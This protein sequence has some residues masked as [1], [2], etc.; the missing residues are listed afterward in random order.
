MNHRMLAHHT[1][2]ATYTVYTCT[3]ILIY[4]YIYTKREGGLERERRSQ[5]YLK[6]QRQ[7]RGRAIRLNEQQ[8]FN[9]HVRV[10]GYT[11]VCECNPHVHVY[12]SVC[13]CVAC[14]FASAYCLLKKTYVCSCLN[15][16]YSRLLQIY[17]EALLRQDMTGR[18][19]PIHQRAGAPYCHDQVG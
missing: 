1:Y 11:Y 5:T 6:T 17:P 4:K 10:Y 18:R 3:N 16:F 13:V 2:K 9:E 19:R 7:T 14:I 12:V 8:I 15:I